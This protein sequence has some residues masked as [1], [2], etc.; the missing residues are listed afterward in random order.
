MRA[1]EVRSHFEE[2]ALPASKAMDAVAVIPT[3]R[4]S[5]LLKCRRHSYYFL[6]FRTSQ[7]L[8]VDIHHSDIIRPGWK[9]LIKAMSGRNASPSAWRC[10]LR[11]Y[12]YGFSF[13]EQLLLMTVPHTVNDI[14]DGRYII[15]LWSWY[16][17]L[18]VDCQTR[19]VTYHMLE[20]D[21]DHVLGAA[22]WFDRTTRELYGMTYSLADSFE[23]IGNSAR[24]VSCQIVARQLDTGAVR[25]IWHGDAADYLHE[26]LLSPNRQFCVSCELGMY[27][28]EGKNLLPSKVLILDLDKG[29]Q[30]MLD[31]FIV[32][33]HARFDPD[34]PDVVYFSNH[35]FQFEHSNIIQLMKQGTYAVKF[36]GPASV[37]KYRLTDEGPQEIG[38]FT[39]SDFFRLTNMHVFRHR[40]RK[41]IAAMGFPDE[42]FL[43]DAENMEFIRKIQVK[44]HH[45]G[46][47][48]MIGTIVPSPDG[49]K[50]LAHTSDAFHMIDIG[51][52]EADFTLN[53]VD[54]HTCSNHMIASSNVNW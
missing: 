36:R 42:V 49:E 43:I 37:F 44:A 24:S 17:Y 40:G 28:D 26:I 31:R 8:R 11:N 22:Q 6:N 15:N 53:H 25:K 45:S 18:L 51:S 5:P 13:L 32:A 47:P 14:G 4:G 38:V 54:H 1:S 27:L 10:L 41:V 46:K 20:E 2:F 30:W 12:H 33:A 50:L 7:G 23:R 21:D 48:A 16:G 9:R 35:N 39:Q 19:I 34:E 29:K 3:T 52:G